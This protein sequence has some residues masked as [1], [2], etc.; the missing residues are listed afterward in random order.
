MRHVDERLGVRSCWV[1]DEGVLE[2]RVSCAT[3]HRLHLAE[4]HRHE[5]EVEVLRRDHRLLDALP[6]RRL[7]NN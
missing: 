5:G 7:R 6:L 2:L 4:R 1:R 3:H